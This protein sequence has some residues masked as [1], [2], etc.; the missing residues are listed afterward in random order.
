LIRSTRSRVASGI[1]AA[2]LIIG[3]LLLGL[4]SAPASFGAANE[5][6]A[7]VTA[8]EIRL[9]VTPFGDDARSPSVAARLSE[10][11]AT[12][13]LGRLLG[14]GTFVADAGLEPSA[15]AVRTWAYHSAVENLVVGRV[16][17]ATEF[18][19]ERIEIAIRSGHSG[20]A[21]ARRSVTLEEGV[22]LES[23]IDSLATDVLS[24]LGFVPEV[25]DAAKVDGA[26]A[27]GPRE[28]AGE[29]GRGL[30]N[31]LDLEGFDS[32]APIQ[33]Q[34]DEAEIVSRDQGRELVFTHNVLVQQAN[35]TLKSDR[36]EAT[37]KKGQSEPE[38]LVAEGRVFVDQGG[39]QA[40]CDRAIYLREAQRLTC[41]G[42]A[43]LVQ[44]CDIVRGQSIRFDLAD[45]RA[46]VE[47]AASIVIRP[48][49]DAPGE[50]NACGNVG[51]LM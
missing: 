20:A 17:A 35:V 25:S 40:R 38:R 16:V 45:D 47:G 30:E 11:L 51:G 12:R 39:R 33:I 34:A 19:P 21:T 42:H 44:G 37:Y 23:V 46:L 7:K 24:A 5:A 50:A 13:S 29:S 36:L 18:E 48:D 14:P 9:G 3:L 8:S 1:G 31:A 26:E 15:D 32:D 10:A 4:L 6:G 49:R 2:T 43:E 22:S 27:A 41:I 28:S